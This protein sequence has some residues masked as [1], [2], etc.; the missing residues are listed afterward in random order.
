MFIFKDLFSLIFATS[1]LII[2]VKK[3]VSH[4][5]KASYYKALLN[6]S[7]RHK[8]STETIDRNTK[9]SRAGASMSILNS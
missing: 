9:S 2:P 5:E 7:E 6:C 4:D 3:R 8:E 1:S